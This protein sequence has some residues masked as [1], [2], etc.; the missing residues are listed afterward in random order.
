MPTSLD[1]V[2]DAWGPKFAAEGGAATRTQTGPN[3]IAFKAPA[4]M[5][6]VML[7]PQPEREV[8]LDSDRK[9]VALAPVGTIEVVPADAE[10][11]ARWRVTKENMLVAFTREELARLAG[12]EFQNEHVLFRPPSPGLVDPKAL[13]LANLIREEF[14][15]GKALD[16][17]CV[18][19]LIT[20]F[21]IHLLRTYSSL[22]DLPNRP[23]SGGL[24][25][26]AWRRVTDYIHANL[27]Q[28]LSIERLADVAGLSPSHFLRAFRQSAGQ[29]PH[30]YVIAR[31]LDLVERLVATTDSSLGSIARTAG[32]SNNSHMT[33]TMKRL[34]GIA[35]SNLRRD[36]EPR[37]KDI[38]S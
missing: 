10:L 26:K 31:R 24:S 36:Q 8:A 19:S 21:G 34:K 37:A 17:L 2:P 22:G 1:C 27:G 32:F 11:F 13:T 6:L 38:A 30:S 14:Q 5:A 28:N 7:T 4:H 16:D 20:V 15:R 3:E 12:A 18:S 35:P 29:A 23:I 33:A 9:T 25:P